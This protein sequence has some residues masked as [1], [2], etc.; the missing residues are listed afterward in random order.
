[1]AYM[2]VAENCTACAACEPA[3]PN[4]AID[5]KDGVFRIKPKLCTECIGHFDDP[6]C[7]EVCPIDDCIVVNDT[8]PRYQAAV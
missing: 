3:C 8:V 1:M 7:M 6:Q 2:I 4:S 5:E